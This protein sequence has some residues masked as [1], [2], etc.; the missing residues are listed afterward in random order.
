[1]LFYLILNGIYRSYL[2]A[3]G[4]ETARHFFEGLTAYCK[5]QVRMGS[6]EGGRFFCPLHVPMQELPKH[7]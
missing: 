1:M 7:H 3:D 4:Y 5:I 2:L 6:G